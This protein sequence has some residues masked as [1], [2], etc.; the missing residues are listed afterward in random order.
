MLIK[1]VSTAPCQA[2][3]KIPSCRT[4]HYNAPAGH[5]FTAVVSNCLNNC[6]NP[7]VTH[8]ESFSRH[9][10]DVGFPSGSTIERYVANADIFLWNE[11]RSPRWVDYNLTT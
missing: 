5:V 10:A 2:G 6:V 8:T 11:C 1:N 3:C 4:K 9:A 7:A